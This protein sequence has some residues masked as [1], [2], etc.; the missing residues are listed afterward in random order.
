VKRLDSVLDIGPTRAEQLERNGIRT[1]KDIATYKQLPDL[2]AQTGIPLE[3]LQQWQALASQ[4]VAASRYRGRIGLI[5]GA[6]VLAALILEVRPLFQSPNAE[7]EGDAF[8]EQGN[9]QKAL[10]RYSKAVEFNPGSATAYG[11]KGSAL[12]MLG[13]YQEAEKT[14]NKAIELDPNSVWTHNELGTLYTDEKQYENAVV[15]YD[16][17]LVIDPNYKYAYA[18]A[19]PLRMLGHYHEA[20]TALTKAIEIDPSW[21][22]PYIE[23]ASIFHDHLFQYDSAYQDLETASQTSS[24]LDIQA[25]FAEAALTAGHFEQAYRLATKL[26]AENEKTDTNTFE[27]SER[28]AMRLIAISALMLQ[29]QQATAKAPLQEFIAYYKGNKNALR[30]DW[31]YAGTQHYIANHKI[32]ATSR[33]L[34]LSLI[35]LLQ[36]EPKVGIDAIEKLVPN[37]PNPHP[38][39]DSALTPTA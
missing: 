31:E 11:S 3:M 32:D 1:L 19:F 7:A 8:Y 28:C 36:L 21:T 2:N 18:K 20:V 38:A 17:A 25:D 39:G 10:G 30:R 15:E 4:K 9:Y 12:R 23:R 16:K 33:Q 5:I 34:M 22:W 26:L 27:V 35:E 24:T 13:R 6:A 14:L 29:N 37:L